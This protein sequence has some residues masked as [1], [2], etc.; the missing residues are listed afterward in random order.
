MNYLKNCYPLSW[1]YSAS[2]SDV[3]VGI[4]I[5]IIIG[6]CAA[7]I[8]ILSGVLLGWIPF[9][10]K[11]LGVLLSIAGAIVDIYVI[12]GIVIQ[13]LVFFKIIQ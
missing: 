4:L 1:K 2:V 11:L 13:L 9:L 3:I 5:Y 8:M 6:A 12:S 7:V 10:G